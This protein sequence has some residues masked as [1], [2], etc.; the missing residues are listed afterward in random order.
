VWPLLLLHL[1]ALP[2]P[3]CCKD[4]CM[5]KTNKATRV[6]GGVEPLEKNT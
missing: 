4:V 5:C 2:P 1:H 3:V 6:L